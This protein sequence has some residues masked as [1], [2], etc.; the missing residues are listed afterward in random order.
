MTEVNRNQIFL[1]EM[2]NLANS[3]LGV[4]FNEAIVRLF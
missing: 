1:K 2:E 3:R 4:I